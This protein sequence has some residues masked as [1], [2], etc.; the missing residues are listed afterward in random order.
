MFNFIPVFI[1]FVLV[2]LTLNLNALI[3]ER[4][5][6]LQK[7]NKELPSFEDWQSFINDSFSEDEDF[8]DKCINYIK[9]IVGRGVPVIFDGNHLSKLLGVSGSM[10]LKMS[11]SPQSFYRVFEIPK[12]SGGLRKICTP[13]KSLK[14]VQ[15]WVLENILYRIKISNAATGFVVGKSI[16]N[17]LKPHAGSDRNVWLTDFK[18][19][20]PSIK[21]KRVIG[22][23][24]SLGYNNEVSLMLGSL[25]CLEGCLPQGAPTSPTISNIIAREF[26]ESLLAFFEGK[27]LIYTR[28]A[29]DIC[30]SG[31]LEDFDVFYNIGFFIKINGF[32]ENLRK[33]K[34]YSS[35][36]LNKITMGVNLSSDNLKLTKKFK[37]DIR[38][39]IYFIDKFGYLEHFSKEGKNEKEEVLRLIGLISYALM[40]EPDNLIYRIFKYNLML[41][42]MKYR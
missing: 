12:K 26:D 17:H 39:H 20:F 18:D 6:Q 2:C 13:H 30:V 29:D 11:L 31:C 25:C 42:S 10:L 16:I 41:R 38:R 32:S 24:R 5:L 36:C 15:R 14:S 9:N 27:K 28:Y 3:G 4:M 21:K 40:I 23:F 22:F 33:R 1:L 35:K 19:F 7:N 8:N 37:K 34:F